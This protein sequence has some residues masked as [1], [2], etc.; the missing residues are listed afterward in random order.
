[1]AEIQYARERSG[2]PIVLVPFRSG[3]ATEDASHWQRYLTRY[4][5]INA[6]TYRSWGP[7]YVQ[8]FGTSWFCVTVDLFALTAAASV[9]PVSRLTLLVYRRC[10]RGSSPG[11]YCS[12]C[13][14]D[15]RATPDRCPE[16]GRATSPAAVRLG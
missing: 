3:F 6:T 8:S 7:V 13:G 4:H 9:V 1:M 10:R 16:C 11:G 2:Y 14:Y 12:A 15:L 5:V